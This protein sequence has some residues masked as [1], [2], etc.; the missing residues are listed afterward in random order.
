MG[1]QPRFDW[2]NFDGVASGRSPKPCASK[3]LAL[4]GEEDAWIGRGR[5]ATRANGIPGCYR[6]GDC[7]NRQFSAAFVAYYVKP[8]LREFALEHFALLLVER[9]AR[10]KK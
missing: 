3:P 4:N 7:L 6:D 10:E 8:T 2:G 9:L 1:R 5:S